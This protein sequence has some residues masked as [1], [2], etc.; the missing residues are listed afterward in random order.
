MRIYGPFAVLA[1][2]LFLA[3][4]GAGDPP[5]SVAEEPAPAVSGPDPNQLYQVDTTVL[6]DRTDG[7]MRCLG[8]V[9]ESLPPQCGNVPIANWDWQA[10]SG[11]E[12]LSGTIWGNYH[13]VGTYEGSTFTPTA[14]GPFKEDASGPTDSDFSSPC[15]EPAGGWGGPEQ[16]THE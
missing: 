7:A 10:V 14:V 1:S 5:N 4:C 16:A 9:F 2:A 15:P 13:V 11:E 3:A 6:E 12:R 8:G